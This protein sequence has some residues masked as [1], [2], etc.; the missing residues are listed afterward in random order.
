[1]IEAAFPGWWPQLSGH[2]FLHDVAPVA[3]HV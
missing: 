1:M 2:T 3:S